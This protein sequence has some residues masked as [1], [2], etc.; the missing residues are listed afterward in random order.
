[1]CIRDRCVGG[2]LAQGAPEVGATFEGRQ[3][4]KSVREEW[5][6]EVAQGPEK[7]RVGRSNPCAFSTIQDAGSIPPRSPQKGFLP[8]SDILG[9]LGHPT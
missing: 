4:C 8:N 2:E 6:G 9:H 5:G 1:M 3:E 7:T